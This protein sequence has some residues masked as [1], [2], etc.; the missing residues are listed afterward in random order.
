M[1]AEG[2][3]VADHRRRFRA[4][5]AFSVLGL[6]VWFLLDAIA[7]TQYRA[8]REMARLMLNQ[9]RSALVVRGAEVMLAR[10]EPVENLEGLNPLPL[11][12]VGDGSGFEQRC[13]DLAPTD[14]G[15]CF[16]EE[17]RWLVYQ[18]GQPLTLGGRY[19]KPGDRFVWQVRVEY[20]ATVK[21]GK[22]SGKRAVGLKLAE[23]DRH[24]V[25]ENQQNRRNR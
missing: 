14:R 15:W 24:Q 7:E 21:Q 17:Q 9:V 6:A 25:S 11:L 5:V 8:E 3:I 18:P 16:D 20:A 1:G 19:R 10:N 22:N 12:D 23:V 13:Q 4:L 2:R